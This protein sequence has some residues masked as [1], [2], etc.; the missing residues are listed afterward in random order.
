MTPPFVP[1]LSESMECV[2]TP[3]PGEVW[4]AVGWLM[5]G[6]VD[7]TMYSAGVDWRDAR[8]G[9]VQSQT[10]DSMFTNGKEAEKE[11]EEAWV[12]L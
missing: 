11:G 4:C 5:V 9:E 7:H 3:P 12:W 2:W 6:K 8:E 10:P 1:H